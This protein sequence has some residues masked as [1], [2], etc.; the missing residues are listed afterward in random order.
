[1]IDPTADEAGRGAVDPASQDPRDW[2]VGRLLSAAARRVERE[3]NAHLAT[4]DLNHAS[5]PVLVHLTRGPLSQRDLARLCGVTEQTTSRVLDRMERTGY[6]TRTTHPDDRRRHTIALTDEG[7]TVLRSA[8]DPRPAEQMV[9]R[10][11]TPEQVRQLRDLLVLVA[12]PEQAAERAAAPD[13]A[14]PPASSD[15]ATGPA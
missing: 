6:V 13:H 14:A 15:A 5:L 3:F 2:P 11:L 7:R 10:G 8:G 12:R 9:T 1:M 4:W